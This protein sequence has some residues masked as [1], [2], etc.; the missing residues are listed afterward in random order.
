MV[1]GTDLG[2]KLTSL[3]DNRKR[4]IVLLVFT[5]TSGLYSILFYELAIDKA[6]ESL[7]PFPQLIDVLIAAV[8]WM[9]VLAL[10]VFYSTLGE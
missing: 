2:A 7:S 6:F 9:G 10:T 8:I 4:T 5:V 3:I 1:L